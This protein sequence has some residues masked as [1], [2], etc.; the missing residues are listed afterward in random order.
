VGPRRRR[1]VVEIDSFYTAGTNLAVSDGFRL[2]AFVQF[3]SLRNVLPD[4]ALVYLAELVL[5]QVHSPNSNFT[6]GTGENR[7]GVIVPDSLPFTTKSTNERRISFRSSIVPLGGTTVTMTVTPYLFDQQEGNVPNR[8][9][10]LALEEEGTRIRHFEF[11]GAAAP[12]TLRPRLRL[13]YGF[14]APFEGDKR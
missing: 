11:Y 2:H 6:S 7:L 8:G 9:M 14:P 3:D 12:D 10:I 5:T 4:S 13:V 1:S